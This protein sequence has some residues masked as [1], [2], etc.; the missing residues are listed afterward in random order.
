MPHSFFDIYP[1]SFIGV[2][3]Y[4][5]Q[6]WLYCTSCLSRLVFIFWSVFFSSLPF[7]FRA[8]P[9]PRRAKAQRIANSPFPHLTS[10]CRR[11]ERQPWKFNSAVCQFHGPTGGPTTKTSCHSSLHVGYFA[12]LFLSI[13]RNLQT[14][15][16]EK[17]FSYSF[18]TLTWNFICPPVLLKI[19]ECAL[20]FPALWWEDS[21]TGW[22]QRHCVCPHTHTHTHTHTHSLPVVLTHTGSDY[23][24]F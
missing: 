10:V 22:S 23:L 6:S 15:L 16:L 19:K 20:N 17:H 12:P 2:I 8:P 3:Q 9:P 7:I 1:A 5:C 11:G 24:Q 13:K 18:S 14:F 21:S 4:L